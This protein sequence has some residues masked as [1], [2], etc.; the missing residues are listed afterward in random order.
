MTKEQADK[1]EQIEALVDSPDLANALE[2]EEF[3]KFLDQV[4]IAIS[5]SELRSRELIVYA[6][7]EFERLSD[8]PAAKLFGQPW[9]VLEGEG[10]GKQKE[11]SIADAIVED[12]DCVG[13][14]KLRRAGP[15]PAIVDVYSNSIEKDELFQT[16]LVMR[17]I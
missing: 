13:T 8:S 6:N 9:S 10:L 4:P 12:S 5:V 7:P 17:G 14:F 1:A 11:R 3:K 15:E 16:S 2:S